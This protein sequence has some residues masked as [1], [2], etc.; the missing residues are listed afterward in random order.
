MSERCQLE[1]KDFLVDTRGLEMYGYVSGLHSW[2]NTYGMRLRPNGSAGR[3][4]VNI[5]ER[6]ILLN[7]H[8]L[9]FI[10]SPHAL[11]HPLFVQPLI[12]SARFDERHA[13]T[14]ALPLLSL[15]GSRSAPQ[16]T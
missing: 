4:Y 10:Q 14:R 1:W 12:L 3:T 9:N 5:L 11:A 7:A 8:W 13:P 2:H 16:E 15:R 6:E